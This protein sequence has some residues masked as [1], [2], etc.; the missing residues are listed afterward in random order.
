MKWKRKIETDPNEIGGP[1]YRPILLNS[2]FVSEKSGRKL[3]G[4]NDGR[5]T[6][7]PRLLCYHLKLDFPPPSFIS[8]PIGNVVVQSRTRA[9]RKTTNKI[10]WTNDDHRIID[11]SGMTSSFVC[12][13]SM[14]WKRNKRK[15]I[16]C[17][18]LSTDVDWSYGIRE[19]VRE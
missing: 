1:P 4:R 18:K 15:K 2:D 12:C 11:I 19:M 7:S 13:P 16:I 17:R 6:S 3:S 8:Y 10:E 9:N 14:S 5:L